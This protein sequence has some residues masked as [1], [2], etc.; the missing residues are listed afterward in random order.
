MKTNSMLLFS[1]MILYVFSDKTLAAT[2]GS[3]T[4]GRIAGYTDTTGERAVDTA[5][6][7]KSFVGNKGKYKNKELG[8]LLKDLPIP[9]RSAFLM[10]HRVDSVDGLDLAFDERQT[11]LNKMSADFQH[12][13]TIQLHVLF[14]KPMPVAGYKAHPLTQGGQWDENDLQNFGQ[15]RIGDIC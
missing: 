2:G 4:L 1:L 11:A 15:Q 3:G 6:M 7:V 13:T 14:V 8:I 9:V 10:N 5:G 12:G